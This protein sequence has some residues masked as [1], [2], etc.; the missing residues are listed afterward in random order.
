[1][2]NFT[3]IYKFNVIATAQGGA[4][5]KYPVFIYNFIDCSDDKISLSKSFPDQ[6]DPFNKYYV[7]DGG[8]PVL[9]TN[10]YF[11]SNFKVSLKSR[12]TNMLA[13]FCP[14]TDFKIEKV[15]SNHKEIRDF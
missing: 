14:F 3:T 9:K 10:Q 6:T 2:N 15:V 12:F 5:L 4:F 13:E 8:Y 1:M 11:E 7:L